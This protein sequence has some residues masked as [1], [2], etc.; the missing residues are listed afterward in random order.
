MLRAERDAV[1]LRLV[2]AEPLA[3]A[4]VGIEVAL[5]TTLADLHD[6]GVVH[7]ALSPDHVLVDP[8]GRPV[9]C[10]FG[11]AAVD[12]EPH[13][14]DAA[15]DV[16]ALARILLATS[17][18]TDASRSRILAG[19]ARAGRGGPSAREL[20]RRLA[21]E[22]APRRR[23]RAVP[24]AVA[25]AA[26]T[27][28]VALAFVRSGH[29]VDV[30]ACPPVDLGCGPL[31]RPGGVV[32]TRSGRF[33]IGEPGDVLVVGRWQCRVAVPALL[34][35]TTGE[36]WMWDAWARASGPRPAHLVDRI[37]AAV[38]LRVEPDGKR[39]DVLH[40]LRRATAA[41]VI[42]PHRPT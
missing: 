25:V 42:H 2:D 37:P 38:S 30:H 35:P 13:G 41:V 23:P 8:A 9:L 31:P 1:T 39:C 40:V 29:R 26:S 34:R 19:A 20:A 18:A 15:G 6:L 12:A 4:T 28:I 21:V 27:V 10:S 11:R 5:A 24:V 14:D 32:A 3:A 16:A 17:T 33:R 36:I 7:R 22:P